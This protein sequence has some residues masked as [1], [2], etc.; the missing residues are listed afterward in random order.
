MKTK[1]QQRKQKAK[2]ISKKREKE[3]QLET[4]KSSSNQKKTESQ[5][6]KSPLSVFDKLFAFGGLLLGGILVNAFEG[7]KKKAEFTIDILENE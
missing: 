7:I 5:L 4:Q 3:K 6:A 2:S 1:K